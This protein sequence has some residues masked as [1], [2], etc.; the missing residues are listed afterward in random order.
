[1]HPMF[2]TARMDSELTCRGGHEPLPAGSEAIYVEGM[3]ELIRS[4]VHGHPYCGYD[5]IRVH[6]L[7][8]GLE[9]EGELKDPGAARPHLE[10][11]RKTR[12][13][14]ADLEQAASRA[15]FGRTRGTR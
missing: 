12:R 1:V 9:F 2:R 15:E 5:H 3:N 4:E 6:A 11:L 7:Q 14:W 13:A 8:R 10:H